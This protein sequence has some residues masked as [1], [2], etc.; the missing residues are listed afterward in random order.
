MN[1]LVIYKEHHKDMPLSSELP[2]GD[3][4]PIWQERTVA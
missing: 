1:L 4:Y 2:C 3:R